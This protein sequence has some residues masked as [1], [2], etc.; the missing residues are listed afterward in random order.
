MPQFRQRGGNI[1]DRIGGGDK[2][3]AAGSFRPGAMRSQPQQQSA[4]PGL[5]LGIGKEALSSDMVKENIYTP[6]MDYAKGIFADTATE[7]VSDMGA[8]G[9]EIATQAA[10]EAA[11]DVAASGGMPAGLV[12]TG[13]NLG[14]QALGV[15]ATTAGLAGD[16]AKYGTAAMGGPAGLAAMAAMDLLDDGEIMGLDI[17]KGIGSIFG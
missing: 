3:M 16:A 14:A 17:G 13:V 1:F 5:A 4:I 12:G 10:G 11:T 8:V 2:N 15:D 6:A 9:A 7:A